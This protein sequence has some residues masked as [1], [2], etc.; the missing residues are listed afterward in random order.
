MRSSGVDVGLD[1][2]DV[3]FLRQDAEHGAH[4]L[5]GESVGTG[6]IGI[7]QRFGLRSAFLIFERLFEIIERR[8]FWG[9]RGRCLQF[10]RGLR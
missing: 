4:G 6:F 8:V 10:R 3:R 1:V 9:G 7:R 5:I 2:I